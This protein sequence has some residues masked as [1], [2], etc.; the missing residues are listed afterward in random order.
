MKIDWRAVIL[1]Q[2]CV[3]NFSWKV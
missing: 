3:R 1:D 2:K